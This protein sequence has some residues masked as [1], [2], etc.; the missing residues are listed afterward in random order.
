[1]RGV[2]DTLHS[3]DLVIAVCDHVHE[4]LPDELSRWHWSIPDPVPAASPAS[5][6]DACRTI[7]TRVRDLHHALN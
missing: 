5:F 1:M 3:D 7:R 4:T 2:G 6:D